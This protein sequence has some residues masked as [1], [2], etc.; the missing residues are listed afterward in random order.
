M[1]LKNLP[2]LLSLALLVVGCSGY[3]SG[4]SDGYASGYNTTCNIRATR[5]EGSSNPIYKK[6]YKEGYADGSLACRIRK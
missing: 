1:S 5:V 3:D 4:Y 6:G 2:T